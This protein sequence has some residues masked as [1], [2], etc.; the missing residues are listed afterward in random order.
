MGTETS[1]RSLALISQ[2]RHDPESETSLS[3][4]ES[5]SGGED[6]NEE[7]KGTTTFRNLDL[8]TKLASFQS[9]EADPFDPYLDRPDR[10]ESWVQWFARVTK[11]IEDMDCGQ[12]SANTMAEQIPSDK[13]IYGE[14]NGY[15]TLWRFVK[16]LNLAKKVSM[17]RAQ[18]VMKF[19][20]K[21]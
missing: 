13:G 8:H 14:G 6:R 12:D 4:Q 2:K 16:G 20:K 18:K 9:S 1:E 3:S 15:R 19:A 7:H 5:T 10:E 17:S 21:E 11:E